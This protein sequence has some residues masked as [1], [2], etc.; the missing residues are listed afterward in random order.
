MQEYVCSQHAGARDGGTSQSH[1]PVCLHVRICMFTGGGGGIFTHAHH[2]KNNN[3]DCQ[4]KTGKES[5]RETSG[6]ENYKL[7]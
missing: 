4:A 6:K 1:V 7:Q 3:K 2:L 5:Q